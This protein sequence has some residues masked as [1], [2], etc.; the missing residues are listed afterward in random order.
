MKHNLTIWLTG[1]AGSGKSYIAQ[2]LYRK[3]KEKYDNVI[4]LDGDDLRELLGYFSYDKK[5]RMDVSFKRSDFARFLSNQGMIV[6][7]SAISMWNEIYEYNR[8]YLKNY[9]EI[10]IKCEFEELKRRDKKNLYTQAL[11]GEISN[12][13]GVDIPYDEPKADL[14]I[15]NTQMT[16]VDDKVCLILTALSQN[17]DNSKH[18]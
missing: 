10:Y 4:Y 18:E 16:A 9:F 1:L 2:A 12:V 11:K 14:V 5:G 3:L 7:V 13:V 15:D 17:L 8:K 6:I